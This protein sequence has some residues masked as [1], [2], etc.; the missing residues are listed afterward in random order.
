VQTGIEGL[1]RD[2]E[3]QAIP[4]LRVAG[5]VRAPSIDERDIAIAERNFAV[6][7]TYRRRAHEADGQQ[8]GVGP[9]VG[10]VARVDLGVANAATRN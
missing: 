3:E 10:E 2:L 8:I 7:L 4:D 6:I 9:V 1:E 5:D